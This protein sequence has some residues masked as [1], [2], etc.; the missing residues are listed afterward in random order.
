MYWLSGW[1]T[2]KG[3]V[4]FLALYQYRLNITRSNINQYEQRTYKL[5]VEE[6]SCHFLFWRTKSIRIAYSEYVSVALVI[7]HA[8]AHA[9]YYIVICGLSVFITFS[10]TLSYIRHDIRG[11]II[12]YKILIWFS[13]EFY[14][15]IFLLKGNVEGIII[16]FRSTYKLQVIVVRF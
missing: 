1:N 14:F 6:R 3:L 12:E 11:D 15:W 4:V 16:V 13:L 5:N 7:E 10:S 9:P 8:K 2:R